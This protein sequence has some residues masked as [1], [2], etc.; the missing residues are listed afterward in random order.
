MY[1]YGNAKETQNPDGTWKFECQHGEKECTGNLLEVSGA[2]KK[3]KIKLTYLK[4]FFWSSFISPVVLIV[5][6]VRVPCSFCWLQINIK[7]EDLKKSIGLQKMSFDFINL[8]FYQIF[9][10]L[11]PFLIK[12]VKYKTFIVKKK[13]LQEASVKGE[14]F[15]IWIVRVNLRF[16]RK[17]SPGQFSNNLKII[18][19]VL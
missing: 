4:L 2:A 18:L 12:F 17:S 3:I 5:L 6:V 15:Y 16:L 11:W 19:F 14:R 8:T 1:P 9:K 13:S 10:K 7:P